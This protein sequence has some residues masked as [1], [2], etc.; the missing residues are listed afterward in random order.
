MMRII[1]SPFFICDRRNSLQQHSFLSQSPDNADGDGDCSRGEGIL[2]GCYISSSRSVQTASW[3]RDCTVVLDS[4]QHFWQASKHVIWNVPQSLCGVYRGQE[5][6]QVDKVTFS[7]L[8][9]G[10]RW[11]KIDHWGYWDLNKAVERRLLR[12][13][14]E[15]SFHLYIVHEGLFNSSRRDIEIWIRLLR[16]YFFAEATESIFTWISFMEASSTA[17]AIEAI[18]EAATLRSESTLAM[19]WRMIS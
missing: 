2:I 5:H 12:R 7:Y 1:S 13:S 14:R 18:K 19:L 4:T 16:E 3:K 10:V 8:Q 15:V 17:V 6:S 9:I 11:S